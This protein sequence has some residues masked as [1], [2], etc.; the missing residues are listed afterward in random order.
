MLHID[1]YPFA[2]VRV[3][4]RTTRVGL[5]HTYSSMTPFLLIFNEQCS[6][7]SSIIFMSVFGLI[8]RNNGQKRLCDVITSSMTVDDVIVI[9]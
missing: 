8:L 6:V 5:D 4:K 1:P 3:D 9:P 7:K 2:Y